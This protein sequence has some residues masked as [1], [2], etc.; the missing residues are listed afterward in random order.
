[1]FILKNFCLTFFILLSFSIFS[2]ENDFVNFYNQENYI[3][4][5]DN[6]PNQVKKEEGFIYSEDELIN[7][8][9]NYDSQDDENL[10]YDEQYF[11]MMDIYI[12]E[13]IH[14]GYI[15]YCTGLL[16]GRDDLL[17]KA[18]SKT[19]T[20]MN[21]NPY[22]NDDF[23]EREFE[24]TEEEKNMHIFFKNYLAFKDILKT[25]T[26]EHDNIKILRNLILSNF[27]FRIYEKFCTADIKYNEELSMI[28]DALEET[29]I[30]V[31]IDVSDLEMNT[32]QNPYLSYLNCFM[33]KTANNAYLNALKS[34]KAVEILIKDLLY[35]VEPDV[36]KIKEKIDIALNREVILE[37]I[38]K[39]PNMDLDTSYLLP[40]YKKNDFDTSTT[41]SFYSKGSDF[42]FFELEPY[43]KKRGKT[44]PLTSFDFVEIQDKNTIFKEIDNKIKKYNKSKTMQSV[45]KALKH[46]NKSIE[47]LNYKYSFISDSVE[48]NQFFVYSNEYI[49]Y[50][51]LLDAF[52][53][54]YPTFIFNLPYIQAKIG[55]GTRFP[56]RSS[57]LALTV[58]GS[59][60]NNIIREKTKK[61]LFK[62]ATKLYGT[63]Y[64]EINK[65]IK[66]KNNKNILDEDVL[67]E[68]ILNIKKCN[69]D[70][71]FFNKEDKDKIIDAGN[72]SC[73]FNYYKALDHKQV[74]LALMNLKEKIDEEILQINFIRNNIMSSAN[75]I[76]DWTNVY[77]ETGIAYWFS[78][79]VQYYP[80]SLNKTIL[81]DFDKEGNSYMK[82]YK[83]IANFINKITKKIDSKRTCYEKIEKNRILYS[84][85]GLLAIVGLSLLML[86]P[87]L[88]GVAIAGLTTTGLFKIVTVGFSILTFI[89]VPYVKERYKSYQE[90]EKYYAN[91]Y[92][93]QNS[94]VDYVRGE[95]KSIQEHIK[96]YAFENK[97]IVPAAILETVF[98]FKG[99]KNVFLIS[100]FAGKLKNAKNLSHLKSVSGINMNLFYRKVLQKNLKFNNNINKGFKGIK[101][102]IKYGKIGAEE[103][104]QFKNLNPGV[105]R[106]IIKNLSILDENHIKFINK[107]NLFE[108]FR[109][110]DDP[111]ALK[112]CLN[113]MRNSEIK[114]NLKFLSSRK[115][116][117]L[118][119][120]LFMQKGSNGKQVNRILN[121]KQ[122][123]NL[124]YNLKKL[125]KNDYKFLKKNKRFAALFNNNFSSISKF[126][127][128]LSENL[129]LSPSLKTFFTKEKNIEEFLYILSKNIKNQEELNKIKIALYNLDIDALHFVINSNPENFDLI[130]RFIVIVGN[131]EVVF[132]VPENKIKDLYNL[133]Y[134]TIRDF[135]NVDTKNFIRAL[136]KINVDDID[137]YKS[138]EPSVFYEQMLILSGRALK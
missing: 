42:K 7:M 79:L 21:E 19:E 85:L 27:E 41:F 2:N 117:K 49:A 114:Y 29:K 16:T 56:L 76:E 55:G 52:N 123:E 22:T 129:A 126:N 61:E 115:R 103:L 4:D 101:D 28:N 83:H 128:P 73:G 78:L 30:K 90:K 33:I 108:L 17:D 135:K 84:M 1:L 75:S 133:I 25:N 74:Y 64:W 39:V 45:L 100:K 81:E 23:D 98:I 130:K 15:D 107:Y 11:D 121:S 91:S 94:S 88:N 53:N 109:K 47:N 92:L 97:I 38:Y 59:W 112:S 105:Y 48:D 63:N 32:C 80:L 137:Y 106:K 46:L 113:L 13:D 37:K 58:D 3:L 104:N 31:D 70:N 35:Y 24:I 6:D 138:L 136:N 66:N 9:N 118:I 69:I 110:F 8:L 116:N 124:E 111:E 82:N 67:K 5:F 89:E 77:P 125:T 12:V 54:Q 51:K 119:T 14:K 18:A 86:V 134:F 36:D 50:L 122:L 26:L 131:T 93:T 43:E 65:Y 10:D 96:G 34:K 62:E 44:K 60:E 57:S 68:N 102:F 71:K 132:K 20:D 40:F 127:I 120:N 72:V 87:G 99:A 95:I